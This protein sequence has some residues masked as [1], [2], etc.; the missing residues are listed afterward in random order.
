MSSA[1]VIN[2]I[3]DDTKCPEYRFV[4]RFFVFRRG[5]KLAVDGYEDNEVSQ[6]TSSSHLPGMTNNTDTNKDSSD[7]HIQLSPPTNPG[8]RR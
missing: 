6:E 8:K 4:C 3:S 5:V 7:I 2:F 1:S